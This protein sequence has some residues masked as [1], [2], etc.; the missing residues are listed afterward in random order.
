MQDTYYS[1]DT[2]RPIWKRVTRREPCPICGKPKLCSFTPDGRAVKCARMPSNHPTKDGCWLHPIDGGTLAKPRTVATLRTSALA[3]VQ[4]C[5]ATYRALLAELGLSEQH[6][7]QLISNRGLSADVLN[8][9]ATIREFFDIKQ[10]Y[11]LAA[12][13]AKRPGS[14]VGVPGFFLDHGRPAFA[15][16]PAGFLVPVLDQH[17]RIQAFQLRL[18]NPRRDQPR[19]IWLSSANQPGGTSPGVPVAVWKP[20]KAHGAIWIT[21]GPLKGLIASQRLNACV[22]AVPGVSNFQG[23]FPLL[24]GA[25]TGLSVVVAYDADAAAKIEVWRARES[26]CYALRARGLDVKLANWDGSKAK[27]V[28]DCL[29]AGLQVDVETWHPSVAPATQ[30]RR[31]IS[32]AEAMAR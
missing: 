18:D 10:R 19:Y 26:L 27:G 14:I 7:E 24:D 3:P 2:T 23:V 4:R 12:R 9:F 30:P 20:E 22:L 6:R 31:T 21:E 5:D 16:Q 25:P 13:V 29:L 32:L 1:N 11:E 17:G 28:D 8:L 15:V